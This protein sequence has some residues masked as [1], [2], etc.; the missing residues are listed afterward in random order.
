MDGLGEVKKQSSLS[1]FYPLQRYEM[2]VSF[3]GKEN[4]KGKAIWGGLRSKYLFWQ[5]EMSIRN[6]NKVSNVCCQ[7]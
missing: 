3:G 2:M 7:I 1:D 4:N 6:T 5:H